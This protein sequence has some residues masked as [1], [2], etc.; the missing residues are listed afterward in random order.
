MGEGKTP[1][2][3]GR[4]RID[5]LLEVTVQRQGRGAEMRLFLVEI[6]RT[7]GTEWSGV[8]QNLVF[9]RG[10]ALYTRRFIGIVLKG[11]VA[12]NNIGARCID[13]GLVVHATHKQDTKEVS[14]EDKSLSL[15][16]S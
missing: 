11:T 6:R 14:G 4:S 5:T 15:Y 2:V 7:H 10:E 16:C 1:V 12:P 9:S 13:S 8:L 3:P